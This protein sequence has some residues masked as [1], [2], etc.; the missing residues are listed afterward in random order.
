MGLRIKKQRE[1]SEGRGLKRPVARSNVIP[2]FVK[3]APE[4][5]VERLRYLAER[6]GDAEPQ[7]ISQ[8]VPNQRYLTDDL[9][10]VTARK[11]QIHVD[12][13]SPLRIVAEPLDDLSSYRLPNRFA[14]FSS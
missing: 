8:A 1:K 3:K 7:E 6:H 2:L 12:D 5:L 9:G 13:E 4:P 11:V 14:P 10:I